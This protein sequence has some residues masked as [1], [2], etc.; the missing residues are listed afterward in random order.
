MVAKRYVLPDIM[1]LRNLAV[2][3]DQHGNVAFFNKRRTAEKL[4]HTATEA[5]VSMKSQN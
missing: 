1:E 3:T 5:S 4:S 2:V